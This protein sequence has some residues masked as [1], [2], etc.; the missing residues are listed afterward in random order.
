MGRINSTK[1]FQSERGDWNRAYVRLH[2]A[3]DPA[4]T[5]LAEIGRKDHVRSNGLGRSRIGFAVEDADRAIPDFR[6]SMWP[7]I[8]AL[9]APA[10]I[11]LPG[12]NGRHGRPV[13][14]FVVIARL[15]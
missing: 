9:A 2:V 5:A 7:V 15:L 12:A 3:S 11:T 14:S 10:H 6:K 13:S 4:A 1:N 8:V